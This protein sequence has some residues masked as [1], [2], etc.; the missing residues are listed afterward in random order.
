MSHPLSG[1]KVIEIAR[2]L[3]GPWVG[4]TLA[5]LGADVIK[6][7]SPDGDD[8][9]AWGPPFVDHDGEVNASYFHSANRGKKSIIVNFTDPGQLAQLKDEILDGCS[10]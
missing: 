10:D 8:T 4:Q 1:L 7:E 5:D 9:R 2:V 3:A 6:I